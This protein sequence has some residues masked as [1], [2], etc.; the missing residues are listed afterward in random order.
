[1]LPGLQPCLVHSSL[2]LASL[3]L[4]A[5]RHLTCL[6]LLL[7]HTWRCL[8]CPLL[9]LL[10][11]AAAGDALQVPDHCCR[12]ENL[13]GVGTGMVESEMTGRSVMKEPHKGLRVGSW[14]KCMRCQTINS[15]H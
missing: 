12:V 6:L 10:L 1:M 3:L 9:L 7:L 2:H 15:R 13:Q 5:R 14:L 8:P 4:P 11:L